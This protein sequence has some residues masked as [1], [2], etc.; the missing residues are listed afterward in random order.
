[1][2]RSLSD[3][4]IKVIDQPVEKK[5]KVDDWAF[6]Y[7]LSH[8]K[9][10]KSIDSFTIRTSFHSNR[11]AVSIYRS[12]TFGTQELPKED[13]F[14][15]IDL[16]F[17]GSINI[18]RDKND[19]RIYN[20]S[21]SIYRIQLNHPNDFG[22]ERGLVIARMIELLSLELISLEEQFRMYQCNNINK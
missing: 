8:V 19:G 13:G 16:M 9:P 3:N 11:I 14:S 2:K 1:M 22:P 18:K 12:D 20:W 4:D 10:E 6:Q 17:T 5:D 15:A 21:S 7:G